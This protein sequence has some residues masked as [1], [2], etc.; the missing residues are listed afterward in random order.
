MS[1]TDCQTGNPIAA[2]VIQMGISRTREFSADAGAAR[3][4]GNPRALARALGRLES[5]ARQ[6]PM[7]GNPAFEPLLIMNSFAGEFLVD[8]PRQ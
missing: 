3:L 4:T 1:S 8:T 5:N 2:T 6:M 7:E